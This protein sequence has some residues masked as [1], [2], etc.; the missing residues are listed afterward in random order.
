MFCE[1]AA[2]TAG[3]PSAYEVVPVLGIKE[4]RVEP[5]YEHVDVSSES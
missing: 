4:D 5:L 1:G 3:E 2:D